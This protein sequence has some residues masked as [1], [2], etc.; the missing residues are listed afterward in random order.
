M[1]FKDE[2]LKHEEELQAEFNKLIELAFAKQSHIGDLLIW[3]NNGSYDESILNF[4]PADGTTYNP[5]TLGPGDIGHSESAH[6]KFI[7]QY[8]QAYLYKSKF[9]KYQKQLIYSPERSEEIDKLID[10]EETTIN[11]EMLVYLKFW[12]SDNII[13]KFYELVRIINSEPYDWHFKI[14][15]SSRDTNATGVRHDIIRKSIRDRLKNDFP[16]IYNAIKVAYKSQI[17]N[18]IAHSKYSFQQRN[19]HI[20][21][22]IE[23]DPHSQIKNIP[24]D[25][26]IT[27]FHLTIVIHNAYIRISNFVADE[28]A[29]L[30]VANN[31]ILPVRI[32]ELDG[33]EYELLVI[34]RPE[35]KDWNYKQR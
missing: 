21:N 11:L 19:I 33:Q 20:H 10:F 3:Y 2:L 1:L 22:F 25:E 6:Y 4:K 35:F 29:R 17:R 23:Q 28:Y 14:Y 24:F 31:N 5:H 13:K 30:A 9:S 16:K 34:F 18:A 26:W 15:E 32:T 12:E 8:R 27:I 7:H